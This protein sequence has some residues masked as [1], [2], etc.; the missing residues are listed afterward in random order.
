VQ[1]LLYLYLTLIQWSPFKTSKEKN[2]ENR[3]GMTLAGVSAFKASG[4][5]ILIENGAGL[6][7]G[8]ANE[9]YVAAGAK[10]VNS[11]K[12]AW[13][14]DMAIKVKEPI[15]EEYDFFKKD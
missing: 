10:I 4:H 12:E 11:A 6:G 9:E 14:A 2:N 8:F 7:S 3:V 15:P 5:E 1:F 13:S